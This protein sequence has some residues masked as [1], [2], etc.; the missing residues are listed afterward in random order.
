M[1]KRCRKEMDNN[2]CKIGFNDRWVWLIGLP[3]IGVILPLLFFGV[4][5]R[6]NLGV[7]IQLVF[8][9]MGHAI[10]FWK[11]GKWV[12]IALR[13]TIPDHKDYFERIT[14]QII[15]I[16]ITTY[17]IS[18]FSCVI[19]DLFPVG[20]SAEYIPS[21]EAVFFASFSI[22]FFILSLY[23]T[24]YFFDLWKIGL[25]ENEKLKTANT[26]AQL[27]VLK[28]QVNPHFLF[29]SLN[30]LASVIPEDPKLAVVF[31]EK[32]SAVYRYVLE[33]KNKELIHLKEELQCIESFEFLLK[34]RFGDKLIINKAIDRRYHTKY[35]IPMSLQMLIENAVKHN[36]VSSRH[37][38]IININLVND[39]II[40]SN[41]INL[42]QQVHDSTKT[43]LDN[44]KKRYN[45]IT[46]KEVVWDDKDG[47]FEVKI[48]I[49][50]IENY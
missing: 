22:T 49:V 28:N 17:V 14:L 48:P 4:S 46:N 50:E 27:A 47:F 29:N 32:L 33:I 40:V 26:K 44:I 34:I 21:N 41:K 31:V 39:T 18:F 30:T 25:V 9:S 42:K 6:D 8:I 16:S 45:I 23:E 1:D 5:P 2:A 13:T 10:V 43:G 36:I 3:L 37:P 11:I 38:L 24:M 19:M 15:L 35:I 20:I 12:L 7:Y